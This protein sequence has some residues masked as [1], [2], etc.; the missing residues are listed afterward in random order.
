[1]GLKI[2]NSSIDMRLS[3][4]EAASENI[5]FLAIVGN[6]A[7]NQLMECKVVVAIT[8]KAAST[9]APKWTRVMVKNVRQVVSRVV[10]TLVDVPK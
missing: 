9:E 6:L 8:T 4:M 2:D 5:A 3:K 7:V 10:E 1:M